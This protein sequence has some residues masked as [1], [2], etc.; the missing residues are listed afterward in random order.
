VD[1]APDD[2][3]DQAPFAATLIRKLPGPDRA[4]YWLARV[5][6]VLK[7]RTAHDEKL[8]THVVLAAR[9]EGTAIGPGVSHLP[10]NI[11]YV[12]DQSVLLDE[13]LDLR[14]T[15]YVAIGT[16]NTCE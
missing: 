16:A 11:A 6:P 3:Y 8:V 2:L 10:V 7:W 13:R 1:Y 4:D 14:K 5:E 12:V 15:T 9:W